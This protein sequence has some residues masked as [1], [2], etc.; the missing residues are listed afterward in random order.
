LPALAQAFT[1][2]FQ[3][4]QWVILAYLLAIT[5]LIVSVGRLGVEG[6]AKSGHPAAMDQGSQTLILG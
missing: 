4:V 1:A 3:Q 2:S 5:A 6:G